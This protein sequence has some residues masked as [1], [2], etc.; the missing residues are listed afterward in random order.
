MT[1]AKHNRITAADALARSIAWEQEA[2]ARDAEMIVRQATHIAANPP[3]VGRTVSG[4]VTRLA[5][6]VADLLRRS[7]KIEASLEALTL[8][9]AEAETPAA[10]E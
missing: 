1:D 4:D 8:M 3:A 7:A 2:F 10:K 9:D 6:Y 5:Q